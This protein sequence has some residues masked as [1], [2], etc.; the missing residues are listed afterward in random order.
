MAKAKRSAAQKA[1]TRRMLEANAAKRGGSS[2]GSKKKSSKK[3]A[4]GLAR[5]KSAAMGHAAHG[6]K[7]QAPPKGASP[8]KRMQL[9]EQNQKVLAHGLHVVA[10]EVMEH[11]KALVGAGL[12]SARGAARKG[13]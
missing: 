10:S 8:A 9:L 1:A 13:A 11:R 12:L 4:K 2:S 6:Y 3:S 5:S 7:L